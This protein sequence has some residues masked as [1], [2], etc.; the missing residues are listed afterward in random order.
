MKIKVLESTLKT[1]LDE[2]P[3]FC[4]FKTGE[5]MKHYKTSPTSNLFFVSSAGAQPGFCCTVSFY[6]KARSRFEFR[7]F[8][9]AIICLSSAQ[10]STK[11]E[12][13]PVYGRS[14]TSIHRRSEVDPAAIDSWTATRPTHA[15]SRLS[16]V[17]Q[18]SSGPRRSPRNSRSSSRL[19]R[20]KSSKGG[21]LP[22][23]T[24]VTPRVRARK[25]PSHSSPSPSGRKQTAQPSPS[26][27]RRKA[28]P[29][30]PTP[31]PVPRTAQKKT[32]PR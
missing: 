11:S 10:I 2:T 4:N 26:P 5:I 6:L 12:D 7:V 29:L 15:D 18:Q 14:E 30:S 25:R 13:Q 16:Q 27:S 19:S 20:Q 28:T 24:T 8:I 32:K 3:S 22:P 1:S 9:L 21:S 17:P 23:S 31:T